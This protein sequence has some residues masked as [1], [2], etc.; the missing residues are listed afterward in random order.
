[1]FSCLWHWTVCCCY[2]EDSAVHLCCTCDHVLY[3]VSMSR[4]V[5]VS[6]MSVL[7]FILNV[8]CR[9][10]DTSFLFFRSL[11]DLIE[12]Y[13]VTKTESCV[14]CS[15]DSCCK[16]CLTVVYVTDRTDIDMRFISFEL[17]LCHFISPYLVILSSR[18]LGSCSK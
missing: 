9:D 8:C 1:M 4:A 17:F 3:I 6:V 14:E 16:S 5:Y 10:S 18:F 15:C 11:I 2:Y 7:C 12:C 13:L